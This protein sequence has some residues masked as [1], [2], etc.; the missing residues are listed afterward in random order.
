M[1]QMGRIRR[2]MVLAL[3]VIMGMTLAACSGGGNTP[4]VTVDFGEYHSDAPTGGQET[5]EPAGETTGAAGETDA[6]G[7]SQS[8]ETEGGETGETG[9]AG[10]E[11]EGA[12]EPDEEAMA[13]FNES[14]YAQVV[15]DY[16][17]SEGRGDEAFSEPIFDSE[18]RLYSQE[19]LM[20][21]SAD[22]C[23]IFRN[24]IYARHGMIFGEEDLNMLYGAF[25]W[26]EGTTSM[27]DFESQPLPFNDTE[28]ANIHAVV[29]AEEANGYR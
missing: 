10:T 17:E 24:E 14:R 18:N 21:L 22:L 9:T 2:G 23:K 29:A 3:C 16:F 7:E 11:T 13:A 1:R 27:A 15:L 8:G 28:T 20:G 26:Y 25:S 4:D 12:Y 5:T 19:E 6:A